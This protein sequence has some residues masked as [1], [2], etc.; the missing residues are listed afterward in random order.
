MF[1]VIKN[2]SHNPPDLQ[3]FIDII[4]K[5]DQH[6]ILEA[7][8]LFTK[9]NEIILTRAPGRMDVMGGIADYSGSLVLQ[10]TIR[11]ATFAAIQKSSTPK[12]NILSLSTEKNRNP[13]F[14]MPLDDLE[15]NGKLNNYDSAKNY[16]KK[17]PAI[18]WAAYVAGAFIV[19]KKEK[20]VNFKG[21]VNLL[22]YSNVPE[23]KGVPI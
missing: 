15:K 1:K 20:N 11:E 21:G 13:F 12:I 2:G 6:K 3:N 19:L 16:F 10:K 8:S 7:R 14:Q 4:N 17:F 23:G 18:H 22:I 5:L 9:M